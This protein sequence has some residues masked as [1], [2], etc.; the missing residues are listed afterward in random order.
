MNLRRKVVA[1]ALAAALLAQLTGCSTVRPFEQTMHIDCAQPGVQLKVN[2]ATHAC[3]AEVPVRRN[4][5]VNVLASKTGFP[6]QQRTVKFHINGTGI[7][8]LAG[9]LVI[10]V[11]AIGLAFP[12][13]FTLDTTDLYID[14][15]QPPA[16]V[17]AK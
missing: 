2:G 3:P 10:L 16:E 17:A 9:G 1:T 12:G 4:R 15:R 7:L 11:P 14:L 6:T 8:D 13:A 5:P